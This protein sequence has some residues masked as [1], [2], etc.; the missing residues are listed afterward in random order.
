MCISLQKQLRRC[1]YDKY[2]ETSG[3]LVLTY[4]PNVPFVSDRGVCVNFKGMKDAPVTSS[5]LETTLL[6][7]CT[8]IE[9]IPVAAS[10]F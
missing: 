3:F 5:T 7:S 6:A 4:A 10:F 2:L 8:D 1:E 9:I